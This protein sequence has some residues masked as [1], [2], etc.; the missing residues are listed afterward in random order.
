MAKLP[1]ISTFTLIWLFTLVNAQK[2][3][4]NDSGQPAQKIGNGF[5]PAS[6]LFTSAVAVKS[7][8]TA[9]QPNVA[10][11]AHDAAKKAAASTPAANAVVM[12]SLVR[13]VPPATAPADTG[14]V[15]PAVKRTRETTT[16]TTTASEEAPSGFSCAPMTVTNAV[17]D[18]LELNNDCGLKYFPAKTTTSYAQVAGMVRARQDDCP[19]T[20]T[21]MTVYETDGTTDMATVTATITPA[22]APSG[23]SCP[24]MTVTNAMGDELTMDENCGL[25]YS[26]TGPLGAS[27]PNAARKI[28]V[29]AVIFCVISGGVFA[30]LAGLSV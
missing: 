6:P 29:F 9:V 14:D 22:S 17:G 26:P 25:Q 1:S 21:T 24:P 28:D 5:S 18:S 15:D 20:R 3:P 16:V 30:L 2:K 27:R 12:V 8:G 13:P 10:P 19:P 7:A 23:F 4:N 11:A